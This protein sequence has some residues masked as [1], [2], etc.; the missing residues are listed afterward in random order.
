MDMTSIA[1]ALRDEI[2]R[3][4]QALALIEGINTPKR[5][6]R[7]PLNRLLPVP[8]APTTRKPFSAATKQ[9]MAKAQKARWAAK[10]AAKKD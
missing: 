6:G 4:Q 1:A 3:L 2:A 7:P 5:R 9:K 8:A 10:K